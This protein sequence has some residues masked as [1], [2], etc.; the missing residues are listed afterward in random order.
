MPLQR[1]NDLLVR[2]RDHFAVAGGDFI[3][4]EQTRPGDKRRKQRE[5][6]PATHVER[7]RRGSFRRLL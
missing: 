6:R 7:G 2:R 1:L 5:Q 3:K 4:L